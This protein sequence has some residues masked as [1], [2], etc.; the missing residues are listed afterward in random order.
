MTGEASGFILRAKGNP[1]IYIVGDGIWTEDIQ[2][3]IQKYDPD[4]IIVNSGGAILPVYPD[5]L[6]L[7]DEEQTLRLMKEARRSKIIAVHMEALDHCLVTRSSLRSKAEEAKIE[8]EKLIIP[9]DG[10]M[11]LLSHKRTMNI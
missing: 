8:S 4:Y 2:T 3:N 7:M 6:I 11:I 1:T 5:D 9:Q 10:E